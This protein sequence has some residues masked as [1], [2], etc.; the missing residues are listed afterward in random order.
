MSSADEK[1]LFTLDAMRGIAAIVVV[2]HHQKA[3]ST[4]A[5]YLAVDFFFALSGWSSLKLIRS[6]F[7]AAYRFVTSWSSAWRA[8]DVRHRLISAPHAPL[9]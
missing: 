5:G 8:S 3:I 6:E 1:R 7:S 2:L 9:R 4:P